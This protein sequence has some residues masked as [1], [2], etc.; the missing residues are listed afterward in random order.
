LSIWVAERLRFDEAL[1]AILVPSMAI[2]A[3]GH[4]AGFFAEPQHLGEQLFHGSPVGLT[5]PGDGGVVGHPVGRDHPE[6]NVLTAEPLDPAAVDHL[7]EV[8]EAQ[9]RQHHG[10]LEGC[11]A[12]SVGAVP[13]VEAPQLRAH[14]LDRFDEE[15]DR[16]ALRQPVDDARRQHEVLIPVAGQE[17]LGHPHLLG[18]LRRCD[19]EGVHPQTRASPAKSRRGFVRQAGMRAICA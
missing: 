16:V 13:G 8:G 11:P 14:R 5:E 6:C 12:P 10:G 15:P 7:V 4:Q 1:A 18:K 17:I 19:S 3:G 2:H 9:Q